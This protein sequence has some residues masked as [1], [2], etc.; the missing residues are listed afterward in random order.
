MNVSEYKWHELDEG[1]GYLSC[2]V[3]EGFELVILT[4]PICDNEAEAKRLMDEK[5]TRIRKEDG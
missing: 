5:L 1:R 4:T 2:R 3:G